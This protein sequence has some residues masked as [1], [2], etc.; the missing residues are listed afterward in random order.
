MKKSIL[1]GIITALI[2]ISCSSELTLQESYKDWEAV[3]ASG[4]MRRGWLPKWL[5]IEARNIHEKH[6]LDS[7]A[8]AFSF[9]H[10]NSTLPLIEELNC[11]NL[12][13]A[14]KPFIKVKTF[15]KN[16][17][18]LHGVKAC[19]KFYAYHLEGVFYFWRN[20]PPKDN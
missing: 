18:K 1:Y 12:S 7:G 6:N 9:E 13:A 2:L 15:P 10:A 11:I 20:K 4:S 3:K 14:P 8:I 19:D 17:H 5:P 16:I